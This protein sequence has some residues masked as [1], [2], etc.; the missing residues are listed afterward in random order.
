[1]QDEFVVLV[2]DKNGVVERFNAPSLE[3]AEAAPLA[4]FRLS[5]SSLYQLG[6]SAEG[7]FVQRYG[8]EAAR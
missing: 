4:R 7:T 8:L 3:W 2:L 1:M 6:S 5:G